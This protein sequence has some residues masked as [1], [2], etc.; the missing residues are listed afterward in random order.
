MVRW[1]GEWSGNRDRVEGGGGAG[2]EVLK[3]GGGRDRDKRET[4]EGA[5]PSLM[6]DIWAYHFLNHFLI[7][8][9]FGSFIFFYRLVRPVLKERPG[10]H[11]FISISRCHYLFVLLLLSLK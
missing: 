6:R 3:G 1:G 8:F 10:I 2:A 4:R 5:F 9:A 7:G 11:C